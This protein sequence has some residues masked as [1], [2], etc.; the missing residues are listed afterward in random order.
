MQD[1]NIKQLTLGMRVA[2]EKTYPKTSSW[3]LSSRQLLLGAVTTA[4]ATKRSA[5]NSTSTMAALM[6]SAAKSSKKSVQTRTKLVTA[7]AKKVKSDAELG[8]LIEEKHEVTGFGVAAQTA[9][10]VVLQR[11]REAERE[12]VLEELK[13]KSAPSSTVRSNVSS[14]AWCGS[15]SAKPSVSSAK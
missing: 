9:K 2:E 15:N 10:Q 6:S 4:S 12:V 14:H 5:P 11:L 1:L 8:D 13:T 7:D 3:K